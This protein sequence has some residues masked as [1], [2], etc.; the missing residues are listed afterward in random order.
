MSKIYEALLRAELERTA[1]Q[2]DRREESRDRSTEIR[3]QRATPLPRADLP[4][5][6]ALTSPAAQSSNSARTPPL[7][8]TLGQSVATEEIWE[9]QNEK[10]PALGNRGRVVEQ[11]RTLRSRLQGFRNEGGGGCLVVSS[12][13]PQEGKSFV[14]ANLAVTFARHRAAKVLLIDG[15][16]RRSTLHKILGAPS[17]PG[18]TEYLA[19]KASLQQITQR[20]KPADGA[21]AMPRGLAS[22]DFIPAGSDAGNAADLSGS[23]RFGELL[24]SLAPLYDW[25]IIDSSPV[26]A[27]SD[28]VN[29]ARAADGVLLVA[30]AGVT[31]FES[32]QRAM[33]E[34]RGRK[35]LGVVLN[36]VPEGAG[37]HDLAYEYDG[38]NA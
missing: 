36:A 5:F 15:D 24:A 18:L 14:A 6:E 10:L 4:S 23:P 12:A 13:K 26:T 37:R 19:G 9:Y 21:E 27:V 32:A 20:G 31:R 33:N 30:R 17:E 38:V 29:L 8:P 35:L 1:G 22:L 34:F 16:M 2:T 7:G 28:A 3:D 11:F 25:V